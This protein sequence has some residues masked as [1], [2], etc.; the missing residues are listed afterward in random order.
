MSIKV[1]ILTGH[2]LFVMRA[3]GLVDYKVILDFQS[4]VK[5]MQGYTPTLNTLFD[6]SLVDHN[7]VSPE[8]LIKFSTTTPFEP[9]CRRA[10]VVSDEMAA[11]LATIFGSTTSNDSEN[12]FVTY[13][14][15]DACEW[16]DIPYNDIRA[17]AMYQDDK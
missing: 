8:S 4:S 3:D 11:I 2:N 9:T 12:F 6:L 10:Y 13:K 1:E 5:D 16:I 14:I 7:L 15:E 17:L